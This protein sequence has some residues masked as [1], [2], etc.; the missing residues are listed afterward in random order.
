M[1]LNIVEKGRLITGKAALALALAAGVVPPVSADLALHG[2][3]HVK[4]L[5]ARTGRVIWKRD[6]PNTVVTVGKN[7]MLDNYLAASSFTNTCYIGLITNTSFTAIAAGDTMTSHAGWIESTNYGTTRPTCAW[8][9]ASGGSKSLSSAAS[10]TM[11]G[12]DTLVGAFIVDASGASATTGS[13]GGTLFSAG[14][15]TGGNAAVSNTQVIQ[16]SYT[17]SV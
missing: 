5:D 9:A 17:L 11:T 1:L 6:F 10:F 12:S 13:T 14:Q 2:V 4:A 8:A 7:S 3:F 16:V 15:F